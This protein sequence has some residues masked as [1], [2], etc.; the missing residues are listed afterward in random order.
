MGWYRW[1]HRAEADRWLWDREDTVC[2]GQ[3]PAK[4]HFLQVLLPREPLDKE[5]RAQQQL[6][7]RTEL[8]GTPQKLSVT[9]ALEAEQSPQLFFHRDF[10][11]NGTSQW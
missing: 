1:Q 6:G 7:S 4:V 10:S 5:H 9:E 2:L 8:S 11:N 3:M